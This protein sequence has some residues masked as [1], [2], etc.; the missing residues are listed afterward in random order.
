MRVP[1]YMQIYELYT[2]YVIPFW[3]L[4]ISLIACYIDVLSSSEHAVVSGNLEILQNGNKMGGGGGCWRG[5]CGT[6]IIHLFQI[7][8]LPPRLPPPPIQKNNIAI[9]CSFFDLSSLHKIISLAH[10]YMVGMLRWIS[11]NSL[12]YSSHQLSKKSMTWMTSNYIVCQA[13]LLTCSVIITCWLV[14]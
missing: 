5:G 3:K 13:Q 7:T 9:I 2:V 1:L 8:S 4:V 12:C 11:L 10:I 14:N 6:F